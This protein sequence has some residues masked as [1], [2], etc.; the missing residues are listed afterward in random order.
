MAEETGV[1]TFAGNM[2]QLPEPTPVAAMPP[3]IRAPL[4]RFEGRPPP[5]PGWFTLAQAQAP[6]TLRVETPRGGLEV[7]TWGDVGKPGLMLLHG[8]FASADWWTFVAPFF[9][10]DYR[11]AA[12]SLAGMGGSDWREAYDFEDF[13]AD[14]EDA[15]QAAG[16]SASGTR[17]VVVGQSFAGG[18][19]LYAAAHRPDLMSGVILV[20]AGFRPPPPQALEARL[21][22]TADRAKSPAD[23]PVRGFASLTAAVTKFRLLPAQLVENLYI[24]DHIARTSVR[25][26]QQPD[27]SGEVWAFKY[28]PDIAAKIDYGAR[29]AFFASR[30]VIDLPAAH[31]YGQHSFVSAH[32]EEARGGPF[33]AHGQ[34][35]EIPDANH[36]VII[37]QPL[38]LISAIRAVL[39][40]WRA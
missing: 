37:D 28:D 35:I 5:A 6:E 12:M 21:Q 32:G 1:K 10:A 2:A 8:N 39:A 40:G 33:P 3:E 16:L 29:M 14:L 19:V 17:P 31:L 36:Q 26:V 7:L 15:S 20:D 25:P 30:P 9:T 23:Q 13:V 22:R 24:L 34:E 27:G 38:A 4:A 18:L 11:V